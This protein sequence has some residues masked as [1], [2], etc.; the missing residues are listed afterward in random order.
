MLDRVRV[1]AERSVRYSD[2]AV[3]EM[4][5]DMVERPQVEAVI[6]SGEIIEA[7]PED[8]RGESCLMLGSGPLHIVCAP[9]SDGLVIITVYRPDPEKWS[10]D[11]RI[12]RL[13]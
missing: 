3:R 8:K 2:H 11:F 9:K 13:Q 1:A 10:A 12:R 7:Y 6:R 4:I 5:A